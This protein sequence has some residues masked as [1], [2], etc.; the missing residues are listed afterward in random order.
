MEARQRAEEQA[1]QAEEERLRS[2]IEISSR[3][4]QSD[5]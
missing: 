3:G 5:A 1:K 4:R 2:V